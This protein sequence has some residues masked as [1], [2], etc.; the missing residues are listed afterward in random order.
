[1]NDRTLI[2]QVRHSAGTGEHLRLDLPGD[3]RLHLDRRLPFLALYRKPPDRP[4]PGTERLVLGEA[5]Y[6]VD[7]GVDSALTGELVGTL[8]RLQGEAFGGFLLLEV[9][10]AAQAPADYRP[11]FRLFAPDSDPPV[12]L[13]EEL[14]SALLEIRA[15]G[16]EARVSLEYKDDWSPPGL[17][18]LPEDASCVRLGLEVAP[19]YRDGDSLYPFELK[20][21]HRQL[22]RVLRRG[23]YAFTHE[24]THHRPAHYQ[25]LGGR[26]MDSLA[27]QV[28]R[29][30]T[31]IDASFDLLLS[32]TPVNSRQ[33]WESFRRSGYQEIPDFHYRA[34]TVDPALAKRELYAIAV[35]E[36]DD[37]TLAHL[38]AAKREELDRQLTLIGDRASPRFLAGSLGLFGAVEDDLLVRARELLDR[39]PSESSGGKVL[40]VEQFARAAETELDHY[41]RQLPELPARV[42]IRDDIPGVLVARGHLLMGREMTVSAFRCDALLAHEVGTHI[43]TF[44]NGGAQPLQL[45]QVGMADYEALQEGLGVLQEYLV[46]RLNPA[47]LRLL[48]AR[49]VAVHGLI[50]GADF[51]ETFR[52]LH[53]ELG[54]APHAAF[55]V[56]M[57]V[58][59]GGG[60]V[61]DAVYLRGLAALVDYL[62]DGGDLEVLFTGKFSLEHVPLIQELRWR[63]ILEDN[64]L[65]PRHLDNPL[66]ERQLQHLRQGRSL[67][68]L[69]ET[70]T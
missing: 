14:E 3:G 41:R 44:Y 57:R 18:P 12:Q 49:V 42:E 56:A 67:L 26:W 38:F 39:L 37:P 32:V 66:T 8:A 48:A 68:E 54:F 19:I 60:Y 7:R 13:L 65:R 16:R 55:T 46:G 15:E 35:E 64:P 21:L 4:D 9:W 5:A 45:L 36:L 51:V 2:E 47:R 6:L 43:V 59:R 1:M 52:E 22:T 58:H 61:K 40:N 34:R 70:E 29:Q 24:C 69:V 23:F 63:G 31:A 17:P 25:E 62:K 53:R 20:T 30:L 33:A 10:S 11:A 27:C 28:D 50:E